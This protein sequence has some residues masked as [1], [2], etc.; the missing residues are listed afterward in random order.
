MNLSER[1]TE[2]MKAA[3]KAGPAGKVRLETIRFLRAAIK[4][5][6][7]EK[8]APL[9]DDEILGI[10]QKQV[11]QL[12]ESMADFERSSRKDLIERAQAEIDVLSD[13]LPKQLTADEVRDLARKV[14]AEVG[15]QS[16]KDMGK[17]MGPLMAQ[18]RGRADGKMVQQIVRE[19]LG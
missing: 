13:Y 1:L 4:N 3:M 15:A 2:D 8:H 10:I 6:E 14:I 18:T 19:L 11:K 5:A 7:I 12:K 9:S 16:V 17:V